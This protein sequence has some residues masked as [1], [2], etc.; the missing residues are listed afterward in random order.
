MESIHLQGGPE[1]E[2]E[3][4]SCCLPLPCFWLPLHGFYQ[5]PGNGG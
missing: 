1:L 3:L 2:H 4:A 5:Q